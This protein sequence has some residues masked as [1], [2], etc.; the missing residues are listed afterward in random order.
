MLRPGAIRTALGALSLILFGSSAPA[1]ELVQGLTTHDWET[2]WTNVLSRHVSEAG[3]IDFSALRQDRGD[4]DRV[5]SFIAMVDPHSQP[6]RFPDAH[7]RLSYYINAYNAL[8][9]YGVLQ[10][11]TPA[12]LGGLTK[13]TF[14]YLRKFKVG[15]NAISLYDLENRIIRPVGDERVHFALN[16]MVVSCPRLPRLAFSA[17]ALDRQLDTA[18][19]TFVAEGRNVAV[20]PIG[21]EVWL[22]SIFKF[23]TEDFL[24]QAPGLVAYVN[25]NG[26]RIPGDFKVRFFDYDWSVNDSSRQRTQ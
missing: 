7:S 16:C 1:P 24:A 2:I 6:N 10:A 19:R 12:S 20:D 13:F 5:V 25:R 8:A 15:G 17:S 23:Y 18:A 9:M 4:L 3:Q 26:A 22:S 14:F 11:G 21:R